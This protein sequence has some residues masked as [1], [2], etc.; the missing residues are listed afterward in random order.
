MVVLKETWAD[1]KQHS[2]QD[3]STTWKQFSSSRHTRYPH[4]ESCRR[5]PLATN[6]LQALKTNCRQQQHLWEAA[7]AAAVSCQGG[8]FHFRCAVI[9]WMLHKTR[10]VPHVINSSQRIMKQQLLIIQKCPRGVSDVQNEACQQPSEAA[11]QILWLVTLWPDQSASFE[12][13]QAQ[14]TV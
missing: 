9:S 7:Q 3:T 2:T 4:R 14:L 8:V 13:K 5:C 1:S 11:A 10:H 12:E 6:N